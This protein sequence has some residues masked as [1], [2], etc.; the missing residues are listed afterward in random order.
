MGWDGMGEEGEET[1]AR[2]RRRVR[3]SEMAERLERV[4]HFRRREVL[5]A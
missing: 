1:A 3:H 5:S 2:F 4:M